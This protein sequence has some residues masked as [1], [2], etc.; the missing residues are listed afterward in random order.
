[1]RSRLLVAQLAGVAD[2]GVALGLAREHRDD[3]Q[4]VDRIAR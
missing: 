4:L 2:L 3:R 1:M